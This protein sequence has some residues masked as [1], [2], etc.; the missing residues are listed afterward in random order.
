MTFQPEI[1]ENQ[2]LLHSCKE[3]HGERGDVT[4]K[5]KRKEKKPPDSSISKR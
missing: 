5:K 2:S 1:R 3:T 4:K